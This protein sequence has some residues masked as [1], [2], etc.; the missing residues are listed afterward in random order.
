MKN[1]T[2]SA[3]RIDTWTDDG[4]SIVKHV[5]GAEGADVAMGGHGIVVRH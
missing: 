3:Y 2:D 4:E 1:R 5:T